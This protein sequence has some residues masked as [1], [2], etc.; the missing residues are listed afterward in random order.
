MALEPSTGKILSMAS[1]PSY[2]PTSIAG[3]NE[4]A[5]EAWNR[6]QKKNNP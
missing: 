4:A 3:S 1:Y 2:D 6:L 5:G